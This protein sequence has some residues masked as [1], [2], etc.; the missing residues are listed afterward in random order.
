MPPEWAFGLWYICRTQAN[1]A[2][3]MNDAYRFR[4][5]QIPCDLI[6]LEPG[7]MEKNYDASVVKTW[8]DDSFPVPE[9][10]KNGGQTCIQ[11]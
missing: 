6:G 3:V 4:Q 9:G 10:Q 8:G 7:W 5:L 2:E 11:A 1:D